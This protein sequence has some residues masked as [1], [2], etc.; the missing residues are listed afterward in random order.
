MKSEALATPN[1]STASFGTEVDTSPMELSVLNEHLQH[2]KASHGFVV[3]LRCAAEALNGFASARFMT[4][5]ALVAMPLLVLSLF[6]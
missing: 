6:L 3:R 4:S 1:W 5:L 2:C